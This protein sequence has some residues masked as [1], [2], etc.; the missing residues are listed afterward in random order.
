MT[1]L[2]NDFPYG[3]LNYLVINSVYGKFRLYSLRADLYNIATC[4]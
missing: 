3:A 4:T 2:V 1:A